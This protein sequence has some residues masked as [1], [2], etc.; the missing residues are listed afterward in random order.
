MT[1][2]I[3]FS[4]VYDAS[5]HDVFRMV[6]R[7]DHLEEKAEH[8]GHRGHRMLELRER[9]GL[10]RSVTQRDIDVD[11]PRWAPGF[12]LPRN[13]IVQTQLWHPPSY[14]GSRRYEAYIEVT[15]VPV[16]ITG[17][18]VLTA[19]NYTATKYDIWLDIRSTF[20]V[21]GR[22]IE[23]FVAA[24]FEHGI[25]GEHDFRLLWLGRRRQ[26]HHSAWSS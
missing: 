15:R 11:L 25:A 14:D 5:P 17:G 18:G 4:E 22:K 7:L 26:Q 16:T 13:T 10:F 3:E 8:L 19:I 20:P 2:H 12:I 21:V 6:T 24:Q 1:E 9:D 23:K